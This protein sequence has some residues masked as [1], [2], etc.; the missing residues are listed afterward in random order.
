MKRLF[1]EAVFV[2]L[3]T[4]I[5][6]TILSYGFMAY[7]QQSW[8]VKFNHWNTIL[9]SEFLTGFLVHYIS[10]YIGLNTWY[11]KHGNACQ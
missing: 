2:G 10:E 9:V 6:G 5:L 11:C 7:N 4:M 1:Q 8:Q 3:A